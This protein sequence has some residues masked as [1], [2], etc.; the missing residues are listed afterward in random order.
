MIQ[1]KDI[2]SGTER[3]LPGSGLRG[4][5]TVPGD[6]SISHRAVILGSIAEGPTDIEGFLEGEDN[7]STIEA[8]R[9][10]GVRIERDGGRVS[11]EGKGLDGLSEPGDVINAGNS[12]TTTRLLLGLLAG[13][14]FFSAI[15]GDA[16][17][18]K[19]PMKRVVDPL[20]K[21][22]A[23]ITGR[24]DGGLL[25][26]AIS[27]KRLKGIEYRTPVASAQLKS[28][29]LL[30]G[31]SA[32]GETVIEEPE[33]SR[34]HTE[35]MLKIF[36]ADI[37]SSGN[38]VS[39]K[40]TNRLK[41]CKI[42]VPGDISSA[43]F[44]LTGA[45]LAPESELLIRQVGINP[46]RVGIIDILRKMGGSIEVDAGSAASG[47]P[48]G[49]ILIRGS[50]L[51]G[52]EITG[53][54]LLP[55]IDEFPILCVAAAF[56]EGTTRISGAAELRVKESDRIAAMSECLS[57]IGVRNTETEDGMIIEGTGGKKARGGVIKSRGDHR[58]AMAM[59]IA[60]LMTEE[61]VNIEGA[62]SVDVSFPGFFDLLGMT[63][64]G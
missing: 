43:A 30:A 5:I 10:M 11:V 38:S 15:T 57:A 36:G 46:T 60:A 50:R 41:G 27:G 63:R 61:G 47:E 54:E 51:R 64:V 20:R 9:L 59:A 62:G 8:F 49:N 40:S 45:T 14:P 58:I 44:F 12:G 17:L 34:D 29:L 42:I 35:R 22:G 16:S 52:V 1:A 2:F 56:A 48:V 4:E 3:A 6:K 39:L 28:A 53:P 13:S 26:I 33:K 25:P 21:M 23:V 32:D 55:A 18:R 24:K 19:R 7:L 31:L 37:K